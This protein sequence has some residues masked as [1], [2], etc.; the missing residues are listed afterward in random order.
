MNVTWKSCLVRVTTVTYTCA[1]TYLH[2]TDHYTYI[3]STRSS[4]GPI[5]PSLNFYH[6]WSTIV[7][8]HPINEWHP[9]SN[10]MP[11]GHHSWRFPWTVKNFMFWV[12]QR[13]LRYNEEA[14]SRYARVLIVFT[15][16]L[17]HH[18]SEERSLGEIECES[19]RILPEFPSP[20]PIP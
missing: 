19:M 20:H 6:W 13:V 10:V 5:S 17:C 12:S 15:R 2:L 3:P 11:C 7:Y 9:C 4:V 1:R 8:A 14:A 18:K 16:L